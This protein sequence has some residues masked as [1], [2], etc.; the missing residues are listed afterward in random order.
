MNL[1]SD[2]ELD[3]ESTRDKLRR[4]EACYEEE[5]LHPDG[6]AHAQ[7]LT[8]Q[9]LKRMINQLKEEIVR[10]GS[11]LDPQRHGG[12]NSM[13]LKNDRELEVTREKLRMLESHYEVSR[14]D[15]TDDPHVRELSLRS[16]KRM[17]NQLKEEIVRYESRQVVANRK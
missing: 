6:D 17:I 2:R 1:Q 3:L 13:G 9:S 10:Y 15:T 11:G 7:E 5:Q 16:I 14:L 8:L 4:L 12:V